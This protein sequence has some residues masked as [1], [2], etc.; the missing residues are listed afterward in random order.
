SLAQEAASYDDMSLE[1]LLSVEV[2]TASK[3][4]ESLSDAPGIVTTITAR[5]IEQFGANSL[6]E[7]LDR[8]AGTYVPGSAAFPQSIVSMRGDMSTIYNNHVLVLLNG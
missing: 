6:L 5:E 7:V 4:A 8:L 1:A 3:N 2:V